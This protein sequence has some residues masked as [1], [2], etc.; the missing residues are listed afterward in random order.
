V[1][2]FEQLTVNFERGI[3]NFEQ[4]VKV[5]MLSF[6][7]SERKKKCHVVESRA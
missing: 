3:G 2:N 5:I 4:G 1:G 7:S 6:L